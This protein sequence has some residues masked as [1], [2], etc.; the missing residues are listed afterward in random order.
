MRHIQLILHVVL[1]Q[2]SY[3]YRINECSS[4]S[5]S[6]TLLCFHPQPTS[7]PLRTL[8]MNPDPP[9]RSTYYISRNSPHR[10]RLPSIAGT[11][12]RKKQNLLLFVEVCI[13]AGTVACRSLSS[14][15]TVPISPTCI[16]SR[17]A[18]NI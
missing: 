15:G 8:Y 1:L 11:I 9:F 4:I 18:V 2:A 7:L 13:V 12:R 3:L 6:I 5:S 14:R 17:L 10:R 16:R